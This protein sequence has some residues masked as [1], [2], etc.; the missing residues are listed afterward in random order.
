M[1]YTLGDKENLTLMNGLPSPGGFILT[2]FKADIGSSGSV[3]TVD[4]NVLGIIVAAANLKDLGNGTESNTNSNYS[5]AVDMFY[6]LPHINQCVSAI[7]KF[8]NNNPDNLA[9]LCLFTTMNTFR[10]DLRPVVN[11]L[12]SSYIFH[13]MTTRLSPEKYITLTDIQNFLSVSSL[14]LYQEGVTNSIRIETLL[15]R[16]HEFVDYF[17]NKQQNSVVIFKRAN[18]YDKVLGKR[19]DIDFVNDPVNA[20]ILDWSFRGDQFQPLVLHVQTRSINNDGSVSLSAPVAFT[21]VSSPTTDVVHN[22]NYPRTTAEIPGVFFN[23]NDALATLLNSFN[24]STG[25]G[26]PVFITWLQALF[27]L[28]GTSAA[29]AVDLWSAAQPFLTEIEL[30]NTI[31]K[32]LFLVELL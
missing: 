19:V 14:R 20:N 7:D 2:D 16:N 12:G 30:L 24:M 21:F 17:F 3:L 10:D 15:N 25:T 32:R 28:Y 13:H 26:V 5:L 27:P 29:V 23:R 8:T 9:R 11:S 1:N 22:V 31:Q 6:I 4:D 18:Y